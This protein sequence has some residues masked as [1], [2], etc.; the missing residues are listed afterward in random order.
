MDEIGRQRP[1]GVYFALSKKE[2][3][4]KIVSENLKANLVGNIKTIP[5]D[6]FEFLLPMLN[7]GRGHYRNFVDGRLTGQRIIKNKSR[8]NWAARTVTGTRRK[9]KRQP[10]VQ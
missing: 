4:L 7:E 2:C 3:S 10:L 5:A 9:K 8:L 1:S 6:F